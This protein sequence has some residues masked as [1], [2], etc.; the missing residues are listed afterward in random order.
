MHSKGLKFGLY[1]AVGNFTCASGKFAVDP[2]GLG[3][4]YGKIPECAV[5]KRDIDDYVSWDIVSDGSQMPKQA[6][7]SPVVCVSRFVSCNTTNQRHVSG[8]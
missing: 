1:T 5:A 4:D 7:D 3:C 8:S 2:I 6:I